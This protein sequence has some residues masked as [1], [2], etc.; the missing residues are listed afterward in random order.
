MS[1]EPQPAAVQVRLPDGSYLTV[2]G[3]T[4][5]EQLALIAEL[6]AMTE[7][8][9]AALAILHNLQQ[10]WGTLKDKGSD[11]VDMNPPFQ[12]PTTPVPQGALTLALVSQQTTYLYHV[13]MWLIRDVVGPIGD[14]VLLVAE[15][16]VENMEG[17]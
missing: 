3:R 16:T 12:L 11:L 6:E 13:L 4:V 17:D 2:G 7:E 10:G 8:Q 15:Q 9:M 1:D 5:A 14:A